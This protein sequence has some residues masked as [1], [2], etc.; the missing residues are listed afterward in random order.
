MGESQLS[1]KV[2]IS[3]TIKETSPLREG[4][5]PD[6]WSQTG[7]ERG[8]TILCNKKVYVIGL[9]DGGVHFFLLKGFRDNPC[10]FDSL[11]AI[12]HVHNVQ[13]FSLWL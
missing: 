12:Q 13:Q 11:H 7:W 6:R 1:T 3:S 4:L 9:D 10:G 5:R 8:Y 2:T